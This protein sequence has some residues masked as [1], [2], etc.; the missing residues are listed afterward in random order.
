MFNIKTRWFNLSLLSGLMMSV[1]VPGTSWAIPTNSHYMVS[2]S[3]C[4]PGD[5]SITEASA[6]QSAAKL[7]LVN[8]AW[9][10]RPGQTGYA[11][12]TCPVNFSGAAGEWSLIQLW[13]RDGFTSVGSNNGYVEGDLMRRQRHS[14]GATQLAWTASTYGNGQEYGFDSNN[15]LPTGPH[16]FQGY[17]VRVRMYRANDSREVAFTGFEIRF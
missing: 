3:S 10:F 5:S 6:A 7:R 4:Q 8:G 16:N 12:L 9:T 17:F 11:E 14:G 2:P 1:I 13:Y 15:S